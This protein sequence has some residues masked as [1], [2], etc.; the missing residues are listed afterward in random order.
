ME[1][2]LEFFKQFLDEQTIKD[3]S[4]ILVDGQYSDDDLA[5]LYNLISEFIN[6]MK[7]E[8][9]IENLYLK[10]NV[11]IYKIIKIIKN[12]N[13][14]DLEAAISL[15]LYSNKI[16]R[17]CLSLLKKSLKNNIELN[18]FVK[19]WL[20]SCSLDVIQ[21]DIC[22]NCSTLFRKDVISNK[23]IHMILPESID[24]ND[25]KENIDK[26]YEYVKKLRT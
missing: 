3:Y 13:H 22:N 12:T 24:T 26:I 6:E 16:E 17:K 7:R 15:N 20:C 2:D 25:S 8:S 21:A 18:N 10:Y 1:K 5:I 9:L 23:H 11:L 19:V 4:K 14:D